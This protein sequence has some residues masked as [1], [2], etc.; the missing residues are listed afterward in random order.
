M[1]RWIRPAQTDDLDG[2]V[3]L[4][5]LAFGSKDEGEIVRALAGTPDDLLSLV[6]SDDK[7]LIGHIQFFRIQ[8][9][10]TPR[11]VGLGPMAVHPDVQ[12]TGIGGGLIQMGLMALE[13][14]GEDIVFVLGHPD[15]YPKFGF[16]PEAAAPFS[17]P[18]SGPAFMALALSEAAPTAGELTYPPAFG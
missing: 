11:A 6:A 1:T 10:G 7:R 18:W 5:D 15:Y 8:V 13:G 16:T 9:D 12:K 14:S 4:C 2:I 17:A 3:A